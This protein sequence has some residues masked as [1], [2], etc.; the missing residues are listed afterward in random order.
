MRFKGLLFALLATQPVLASEPHRAFTAHDLVMMDRVSDPQ[1]APD[2]KTLVFSVRETDY[3]ANKGVSGIWKQSLTSPQPQPQRLTARG[4]SA[5]SPRWSADG[6]SIFFI[7]TR[8]GSAQVWRLPMSGGEAY[9]VT[10]LPLDV[11]AFVVSPLGLQLAL[12]LDVYLDCEDLACTK[13]RLDEKADSKSSGTVYD[14]LFMRHWDTWADGRRS[15][16]FVAN[17]NYD[18]IVSDPPR[19]ITRG[20]DG[21]IPS[22]PHGDDS[23]FSFSPDGKSIYFD[24]RIAGKTEAWSTNFDIYVVPYDGSSAPRNLTPDNPAWDANPLIS[25]D[26]KTLYYTA[27]KRPKFEADRFGI[28][29]KDLA[30][31]KTREINAAWDSSAGALKLS[32][33]GKTLYTTTDD[34][35]THPLFAIDIKS[36]KVRTLVGEGQIE[37]FDIV[38]N[39]VVVARSTLKSPAN[40]FRIDQANKK[41][42]QLTNFN[43]QHLANI[44]MGDYE[45]FTFPGWNNESVQ[46][47][48]VKP[49]NF[50]R[51][52]KYPIAFIVHGGPQTAMN[53]SFHYR[54]NAQN[55]A[56]Q[57]FAVVVI[58][59]H[60]STG[61]GQ[62]FTDSISGDWGGKPLEDLQK[63]YAAALAKYDFLDADRAC[64][65]G[66]S[67]GGYM[68]NWIAGNWQEP[69]KCLV[70]HDGIFD[71]RSMYY[72][73]EELWFDEWEHG[74]PQ[75][76]NPQAFETHN[77]VNYVSK[78]KIP[79]LVVHSDKDFRVPPEQGIATFTALQR[80][81][82]PSEFLNFPDENHWV[83]KP[84]NSELWHKTVNAWL[85]Q[86]MGE[87]K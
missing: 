49:Y 55:F 39:T 42:M 85:N 62:A 69:W 60:G 31:G 72:T 7:S 21:D 58:N 33:D 17:L 77:P 46:G 59:F 66:A 64:A 45:F 41:E 67:Y 11:N 34:H 44:A 51:G 65:L 54:W 79:M 26:G 5:M 10:F 13:K 86:W 76:E 81:G 22:K 25:L 36:G 30:T 35:G 84:Q 3:A 20:I 43:A 75:F 78:W 56:G 2:G 38:G 71:N 18:G 12:S 61:Y 1:L 73:T 68:M 87:E 6:K 48:V 14:K 74:A 70:N 63:G 47:Y 40:L 57:G 52:K 9:Q 83:L 53:N 4:S 23:E 16:L 15:Q 50:V 82:I 8:S 80:R 32:Q 28:M 29:E 24:V 27:M 19:W 37:G